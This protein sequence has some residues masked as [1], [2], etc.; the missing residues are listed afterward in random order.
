MQVR[1]PPG[2]GFKI[3]SGMFGKQNVA[4]ITAIHYPL[5]H[6]DSG[7]GHVCPIVDILNQIDWAAMDSHPQLQLRMI[8]Q[9]VCDLERALRR[10]FGAI[11]KNQRHSVPRWQGN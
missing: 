6:V 7:P 8:L 11:A 3:F 4:G 10:R 1:L 2:I 5:R 9:R